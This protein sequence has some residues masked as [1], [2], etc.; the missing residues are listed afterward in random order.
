MADNKNNLAESMKLLKEDSNKI[1]ENNVRREEDIK[2][3]NQVIAHT[4]NPHSRD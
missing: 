2:K 3:L 1:S 4:G